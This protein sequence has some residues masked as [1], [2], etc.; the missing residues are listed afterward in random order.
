MPV[1][2]KP[3]PAAGPLP[4]LPRPVILP[5]KRKLMD[6]VIKMMDLVFKMMHLVFKIMMNCVLK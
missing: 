4:K 3:V 5:R 2:G 6:F 1:G